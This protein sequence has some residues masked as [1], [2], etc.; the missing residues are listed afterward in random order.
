MTGLPW[1]DSFAITRWCETHLTLHLQVEFNMCG[2]TSPPTRNSR[3]VL[4]PH[5]CISVAMLLLLGVT[6]ALFGLCERKVFIR[7]FCV[8]APGWCTCLRLKS[9]QWIR[10]HF[11]CS[12]YS[13]CRGSKSS[14]VAGITCAGA[15]SNDTAA[16]LSLLQGITFEVTIP[17]KDINTF[18]VNL[19]IK[20]YI[21]SA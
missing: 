4:A 15:A 12:H 7:L 5:R 8:A 6:N 16:L 14:C 13:S 20:I 1:P 10:R 11:F 3:G 2:C 19:L 9:C 21:L 17:C 18:E